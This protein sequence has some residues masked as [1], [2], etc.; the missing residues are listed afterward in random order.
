MLLS[1]SLINALQEL[2]E[3][4]SGVKVT[5]N[6]SV[7]EEASSFFMEEFSRRWKDALNRVEAKY[8]DCC[9][10]KENA[11]PVTVFL[12]NDGF[13]IS[14][15]NLDIK[16]RSGDYYDSSCG[17]EAFEQSLRNTKAQYAG[18]EYEGSISYEVCDVHG[19][20]TVQWEISSCDISSSQRIYDFI[21]KTLGLVLAIENDNVSSDS[22]FW[23]E[24]EEI[25][26]DDVDPWDT[27]S[28]FWAGLAQNLSNNCDFEDT[29]KSLYAYSGWIKKNVL[30]TAVATIIQI[31][32][33]VD[34][35]LHDGLTG[36][37]STLKSDESVD[38]EDFDIEDFDDE[39][40]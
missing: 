13:F 39:D 34:E 32:D 35:D 10:E 7:R 28:V 26:E 8:S 16:Y 21:G 12:A 17:P 5:C 33:E 15:T 40:Q 29:I 1:E 11:F 20:E 27:E 31:A 9:S 38:D 4:I 19:G 22:E 18:L 6:Q 2:G 23:E 14:V 37:V 3:D 24:L 30:D 36:L 25:M